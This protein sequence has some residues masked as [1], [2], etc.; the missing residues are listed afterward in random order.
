MLENGDYCC[1][2]LTQLSATRAALDQVGAE[3]AA[4]HVKTCVLGHGG[5]G[6]HPKANAMSHDELM[7]ELRTTLSRLVK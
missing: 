3:M 1:D 6:A 7:E 2:V 5:E 4:S